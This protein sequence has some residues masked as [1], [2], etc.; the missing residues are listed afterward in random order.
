MNEFA[1]MFQLK[2]RSLLYDRLVE[3]SSNNGML[4]FIYPTKTGAKTF[5]REYLGPIL[6]PLL[7]SIT[8]V[9]DLSS[10]LGKSL[11]RMIAVDRLAEY[12]TLHAELQK[13]CQKVNDNT[14]LTGSANKKTTYSVIHASKEEI[15]LER[16]AWAS[17]WWIKQEKP[18][19]RELVTKFFRKKLPTSDMTSTTLI[20]EV[21]DGVAHREYQSSNVP[22][23]VEVGVFIV[24]KSA[25]G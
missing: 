4:L 6:D 16:S 5:M 2:G 20:Q 13:F 12:D 17:D 8:V 15:M 21:L 18:R 7:R 24:K 10:D 14:P 25:C 11:G 19:V 22:K 1:E 3:L 9:H 23:G